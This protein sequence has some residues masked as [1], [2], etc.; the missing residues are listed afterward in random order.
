MFRKEEHARAVI[1]TCLGRS[2]I[3]ASSHRYRDQCWTR[4]FVIAGLPC[5]LL[6]NRSD[7]Q[8]MVA[9]HLH[10]LAK[11]QKPNGQIP[12]MFLDNTS[13]WIM[14]K[15]I[16]SIRQRRMSFLLR[17]FL[18]KEG[19]GA[20]S[21]WTRDSEFLFVVGILQYVA[22]T[23]DT[24]FLQQHRGNLEWA[25]A[26][27][28]DHLMKDGLVYGADWRDTRPDL[29]DKALL[30]NNCLLFQA[31]FLLDEEREAEA[32]NQRINTQFWTGQYY[33]DY[34]T[35]NEFDTLGNALAILLAIAPSEQWE[36]MFAKV[37]ELN[38]PFGYKLNGVTLPTRSPAE[39]AVM[40]KAN[41]CGVI[42]PFVHHFMTL[43]LIRGSKID[44]AKEQFAK[45]DQLDGFF[46]WYDPL[47]G[48][49]YGGKDQLWSAALYLIVLDALR[50]VG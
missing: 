4:D 12:I 27:V 5:L 39:T 15:I 2:G 17:A 7:Y 23:K 42:W 19:V 10:E 8:A 50:K 41:Q 49:G 44:L 11:R 14:G 33:R 35:S 22:K 43:A 47:T 1:D 46:E 25:M 34:P 13:R 9:L 28:E 45:M 37:E 16:K 6:G 36:S 20:L 3:W 29:H 48:R 40:L 26:Y 32:L 30:T 24:Q 18:S 31:Y 21:P 38:T